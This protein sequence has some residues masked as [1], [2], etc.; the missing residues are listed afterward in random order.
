[1]EKLTFEQAYE[2]LEQTVHAMEAGDL[3]LDETLAL[4]EKGHKL[5]RY[6][7]Q[8]LNDAELRVQQ[9]VPDGSGGF[10]SAPLENWQ[11]GGKS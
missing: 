10:E 1:M 6:C 4:F 3:P 8:L 11:A 7:D 2:Q 5:A 9:I